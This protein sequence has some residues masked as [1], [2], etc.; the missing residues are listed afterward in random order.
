MNP[1]GF[2]GHSVGCSSAFGWHDKLGRYQN[3]NTGD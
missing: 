2:G 1:G 3:E